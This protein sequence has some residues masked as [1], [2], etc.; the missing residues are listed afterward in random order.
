LFSQWVG[1]NRHPADALTEENVQAYA[2][3]KEANGSSGS[4]INR[5]VASIRKMLKEA[6][7]MKLVPEMFDLPKRA[8]GQARMRVYTPAEEAQILAT[9]KLWSYDDLHDLFVFLVDTGARVGESTKLEWPEVNGTTVLFL[10]ETTKNRTER[11]VGL[12]PRAREAL[13]RMKAKHGNLSGPF[14]W[15][16]R[17]TMRTIWD[18]LRGHLEWLDDQCVIHTFRHT[19]LSR[20]VQKGASLYQ[21]QRWAG[22][23]T[24]MTTQRYAKFAPRDMESLAGL[25][26][27]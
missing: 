16:E 15:V 25:L 14:V 21:V 18:R 23:K 13:A 24:P 10:G 2:K 11:V 9:L 3:W 4:T 27:T 1:E 6:V 17:Q 26:S 8:E 7:K 5:H 22:H 19:C 20:L 12:T